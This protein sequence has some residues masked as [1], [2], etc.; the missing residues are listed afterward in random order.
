MLQ[1]RNDTPLA[2]AM[3]V[4][5]D[6]RGVETVYAVVK[7][8]LALGG[9]PALAAKQVPVAPADVYWG[10]PGV[11]SLRYASELHLAK[12]GTDVVLVGT[13]RPSEAPPVAQLD[14]EV[15][16]AERRKVVRVFGDRV[17]RNGGTPSPPAPFASMPL[18]YERAFGGLHRTAGGRLLGEERNPV[19]A[20]F[21]G[22]RSDDELVGLP[23]PNLED[24][25]ALLR[26][27][28]DAPAPAGFGF[29]APAWLPRRTFAGT[30]D[31]AW[32]KGRAPYLPLDFDP[33]FFHAAH[34]DLAFDR[35]LQGGEP[36]EVL[37][38]DPGG[39]LRFSLPRWRIRVRIRIAGSTAEPPARLETV[40]LEPDE[41]RLCLTWRAAAPC[42]K[43][44]LRV[45]EVAVGLEE[46][47]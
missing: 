30:Y 35:F 22:E 8:T 5:P 37:N 25:A 6:E 20:G 14:V 36:V 10:E 27:P 24:P 32:K 21:R 28:G 42:D 9:G 23:L 34:P 1:L 4:F 12:P 2:A 47:T 29:V 45:E 38:A 16:A 7:G 33:R 43:K 13:A 40:L 44:A 17:W 41:G 26:N 3:A 31:E 39:P 15:A 19:G 11:S 46:A 18:V